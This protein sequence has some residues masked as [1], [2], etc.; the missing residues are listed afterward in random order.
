MAKVTIKIP[1]VV[2]R[3]GRP[4]FVPGPGVR[5]LGYTGKDLKHPDSIWFDLNETIAWS[6]QL[7]EEIAIRRQQAKL[8]K[9]SPKRAPKNHAKNGYV[10]FGE[11]LVDWHKERSKES[12]ET[13]KP[14]KRTLDWYEENINALFRYD[15]EL[16]TVPAVSI[17]QVMA[18]GIY[19]KLRQDKGV[20][21]SKALISTIRAAWQWT[22]KRRGIIVNNPWRDLGVTTP[23]PRLRVGSLEEM[24]HLIATA[25]SMN[26]SD[27]GDAIM[28]G[29]CTGQRQND[30]LLLIIDHYDG[31]T[32]YFK[33]SKTGAIVEIPAIEPL[34]DRI[35]QNLDRR[36]QQ[37]KRITTLLF[38]NKNNCR[39]SPEGDS[40][41]RKFKE[42][43]DKAAE[44]MPSLNGFHD[45]DLRDTAIT[46]L[47]NA[48]CS[49]P[50][51]CSITGHD[52]DTVTRILNHYLAKTP[53][54]AKRATRKLNSYLKQNGGL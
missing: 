23:P 8:K 43:R 30:R 53:E 38:D 2:W 4:R 17:N 19:E 35:A 46:W 10:S 22:L 5:A 27:I 31:E 7:S 28:L 9:S 44:T 12:K 25:D 13:G 54:Q 32:I 52:V 1:Y 26:R 20:A 50:E 15:P 34:V 21:F 48:G 39:W 29:L 16:W 49:I 33:Q 24:R 14:K 40:Y 11:L 37:Q 41:R 51:I 47:G 45:Q 36:T 42:I 3:S 18:F 6:E